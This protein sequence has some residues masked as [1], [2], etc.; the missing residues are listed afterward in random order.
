M[1]TFR[2]IARFSRSF[3]AGE[4]VFLAGSLGRCMYVIVEGEV[5]IRSPESEGAVLLTTLGPGQLFGEIALVDGGVRS[6]SAVAGAAPTLLVE[7]DKAR[8]IY[9][10]GQQPAFALTVLRGLARRIQSL[11]HPDRKDII[12]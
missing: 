5:E 11:S 2:D 1:D 9:L 3:G 7:V 8:F 4:I 12:P 6:A 10:V